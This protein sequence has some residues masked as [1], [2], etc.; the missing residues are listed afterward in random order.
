MGLNSFEPAACNI[1]PP[2]CKNEEEKGHKQAI[3]LLKHIQ[4][5][6]QEIMNN[7]IIAK[8]YIL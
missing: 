5:D 3:T 8:L 1:G 2:I 6:D 4:C 7:D